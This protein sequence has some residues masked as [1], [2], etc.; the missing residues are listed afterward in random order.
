[1][2]AAP[3]RAAAAEPSGYDR[4]IELNEAALDRYRGEHSK[5][6]RGTRANE[7]VIAR[8]EAETTLLRAWADRDARAVA[9]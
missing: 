7:R 9:R 1:M 5:S 3:S 8:L 2:S 6:A 4:R